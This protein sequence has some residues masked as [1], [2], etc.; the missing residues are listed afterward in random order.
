MLL[1]CLYKCRTQVTVVEVKD[2]RHTEAIKIRYGDANAWVEWRKY[3][4]HTLNKSDCYVCTTGRPESQVVLF[5]LGPS[6]DPDRMNCTL[7]VFQDAKAWGNK[8]CQLLSLL[9]PEARGP[10]GQPQGVLGHPP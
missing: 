10:A 6:L 7:A 2:L 3:F 9:F 1:P 5:L 4:V 8:S